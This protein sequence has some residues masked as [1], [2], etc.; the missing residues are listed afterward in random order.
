MALYT[1]QL[2]ELYVLG[3]VLSFDVNDL[4]AL[5]LAGA[6]N[7]LVWGEPT[8]GGSV[9]KSVCVGCSKK[10]GSAHCYTTGL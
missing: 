6:L 10:F 2:D 4:Q 7:T 8:S 9:A 1:T 3:R 5:G